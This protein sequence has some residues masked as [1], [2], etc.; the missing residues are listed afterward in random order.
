MEFELVGDLDKL[1][2][3]KKA[4]EEAKESEQNKPDEASDKNGHQNGN[5]DA[6]NA[7][8]NNDRK[9]AA[10]DNDQEQG[11]DLSMP[12]KKAKLVEEQDDDDI[13]CLE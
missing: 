7:N 1:E 5:G 8:G 10:T 4:L 6:S 2:A 13:V 9:R 3:N 11:L 12:S